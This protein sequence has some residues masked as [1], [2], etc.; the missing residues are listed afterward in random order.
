MANNGKQFEL[1][2]KAIYEEIL[3]QNSVESIKVSHDISIRGKSGQNHQIDVYWSFK[4]AGETMQVAIEC[5]DYKSPVSIGRIRDFWGALDDIGNIKGIF[6]T[7]Q[8]YQSGAIKFAEHNKIALKTVREP[9]ESE[10]NP[11]GSI[12]YI[13]LRGRLIGIENIRIIPTFDVPWIL[14]NTDFKEGDEYVLSGRNDQVKI[15]DSN[16]NLLGTLLDF[17]NKLS[18]HPIDTKNITSKIEFPD[19]YLYAPE[20]SVRPLKLK[21]IDFIYDTFSQVMTNKLDLT[22]TAKAILKD[23]VTGE[24]F[25]FQKRVLN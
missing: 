20:S 10:L 13:E 5:K 3:A 1:L 7:T 22:L 8:G 24:V 17:E 23:I 21:H 12:R 14:A 19:A 4:V 11:E 15:L 6:V 16:Y 2:V 9:T 18:R 25:L